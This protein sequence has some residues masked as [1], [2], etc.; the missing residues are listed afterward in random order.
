MRIC[1]VTHESNFRRH[2]RAMYDAMARR[3]DLAVRFVDDG[4][5]QHLDDL[6]VA[7]ADPRS[8]DAVLFEVKFRYFRER[9]PFQWAGYEGARIMLEFDACQNYTALITRQY[10]GQ[11]PSVFRANEFDVM[12]CTGGL[13]SEMLRE[14]GVHAEWIPKGYDSA[15]LYD[16]GGERGE[17]FGYFG[18]LYPARRLMLDR[19]RRGGIPVDRVRCPFEELNAQLNRFDAGVICNMVVLGATKIPARV[20]RQLPASLLRERPGI[21][22][23]MKNFEVA[24]A[25][26]APVCDAQPDLDALGFRD[27]ETMVSYADFDE[28]VDKAHEYGRDPARLREIGRRAATFVA[29]HHTWDHRAAEL[30]RL[31]TSRQFLP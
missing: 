28:L 13:V 15:R 27:G 4:W 10:L 1:L 2:N 25:G 9:P 18:N 8:Y 11:W 26:A 19:L 30:E 14:D 24:A 20:L 17:G 6:A 23:M 22:P 29:Q 12:A 16:L 31:V 3:F 21:E 5:P 7:G